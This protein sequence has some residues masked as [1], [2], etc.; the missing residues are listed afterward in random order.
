MMLSSNMS[1]KFDALETAHPIRVGT[2]HNLQAKVKFFP[3]TETSL[4]VK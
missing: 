3:S 1:F 4:K 2:Q